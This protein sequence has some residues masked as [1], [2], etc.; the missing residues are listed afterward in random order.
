MMT[1]QSDEEI[2][3]RITDSLSDIREMEVLLD[4]MLSLR[5]K[6][7]PIKKRIDARRVL[8]TETAPGRSSAEEEVATLLE[9][10]RI[11]EKIGTIEGDIADIRFRDRSLVQ[12]KRIDIS[13]PAEEM[14]RIRALI[15]ILDDIEETDSHVEAAEVKV[16]EGE[17]RRDESERDRVA[18]ER[19]MF[20]DDL[21]CPLCGQVVD[22]DLVGHIVLEGGE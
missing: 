15:D 5:K 18:L 19:E 16:R 14:D 9:L 20:G 3:D 6:A 17:R 11:E 2:R 22:E 21:T 7:L 12:K 1:I 8:L 10:V 4:G 13:A